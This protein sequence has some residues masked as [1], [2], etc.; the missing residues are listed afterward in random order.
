[1]ADKQKPPF[2]RCTNS[3]CKK[4]EGVGKLLCQQPVYLDCGG[5]A[6]E[7]MAWAIM[8]IS[9]QTVYDVAFHHPHNRACRYTV[10][11]RYGISPEQ[12]KQ[13]CAKRQM[14]RLEDFTKLRRA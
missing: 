3:E 9:C 12:I 10:N 14:L 11:E 6:P 2:P 8:C 5:D 1:M 7:L 4:D 13:V